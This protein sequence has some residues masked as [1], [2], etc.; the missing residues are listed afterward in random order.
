MN[1]KGIIDVWRSQHNTQWEYTYYSGRHNTYS[2]IDYIFQTISN[3]VKLGK[4]CI[5]PWDY[6][7]HATGVI[8]WEIYGTSRPT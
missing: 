3:T 4:S 7:D 8:E 1:E 5:G 2:R 6:S